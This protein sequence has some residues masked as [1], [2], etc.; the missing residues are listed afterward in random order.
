[1]AAM[2]EAQKRGAVV[3]FTDANCTSCHSSPA[4]SATRFFAL[5]V[6]DLDDLV[7]FNEGPEAA[8][9]NLGRGNF[10]GREEDMFKFKVPTLYNLDGTPFY[11]HGSSKRSLE[12]VVE[13]FDNAIPENPDVPVEQIAAEFK[14]LN[15]TQQQRD[16]LVAFLRY[17]LKDTNVEHYMPS[18]LPSGRCF[19]NADMQ[20]R[21][22][23]GCE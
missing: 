10:T 14:P 7:S 11:F 19:P 3:F 2:T 6:N 13:Y 16:D 17:G 21:R 9:K 12:E 18:A 8:K 22:E 5:G 23:I 20:S 4:F 15:L 1:M